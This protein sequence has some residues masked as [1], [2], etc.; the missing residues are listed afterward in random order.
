VSDVLAHVR[1][2]R[3]ACT[4]SLA[5]FPSIPPLLVLPTA[6]APTPIPA[7]SCSARIS[8]IPAR[9]RASPGANDTANRK[10]KKRSHNE[11]GTQ[12][13]RYRGPLYNRHNRAH[14]SQ[15]VTLKTAC[16][17]Q[18]CSCQEA[19]A[20]RKDMTAA[21]APAAEQRVREREYAREPCVLLISLGT[22]LAAMRCETLSRYLAYS[23]CNLSQRSLESARKPAF[24]PSD[25]SGNE[26][27]G[28]CVVISLER[29][30]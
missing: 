22:A 12:D 26:S 20:A 17:E 8:A 14:W 6:P 21:S 13:A 27:V 4:P 30:E 7:R 1:V 18:S 2:V 28:M 10:S 3:L 5:R 19:R 29:E 15:L 23:D 11:K 24:R 25:S 9:A 16:A